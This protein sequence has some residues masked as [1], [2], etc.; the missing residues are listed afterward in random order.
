LARRPKK[1]K[2]LDP[3]GH[4]IGWPRHCNNPK[5][6]A[7]AS[8]S[9]QYRSYFTTSLQGG[10]REA[11]IVLAGAI[12]VAAGRLLPCLPGSEFLLS[13]RGKWSSR[14]SPAGTFLVFSAGL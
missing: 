10:S 12:F 13:I 2:Q 3:H 7:A 9:L 14:I 8:L 4:F 6:R 5:K 1:Q 11:R